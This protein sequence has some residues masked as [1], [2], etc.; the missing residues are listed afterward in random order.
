MED[1]FLESPAWSALLRRGVLETLTGGDAPILTVKYG[2]AHD[3]G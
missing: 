1:E 2:G 3:Q